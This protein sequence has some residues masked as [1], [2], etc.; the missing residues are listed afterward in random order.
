MHN[1]EPVKTTLYQSHVAAGA[2]IVDFHGFMMPLRYT[3]ETREHLNVRTNAGLFD[4]SHMGEIEVTGPEALNYLQ[5]ITPNNVGVLRPGQCQYSVL[6]REDGTAVDDI[7]ISC[8]GDNHYFICVNAAN[9]DKDF[10]HFCA[11]VPKG[12][13]VLDL[14]ADYDQL[15]IQGPKALTLLAALCKD[16]VAEMPPFTFI[17]TQI[18][19][20]K[21]IFAT[22]GYTGERGGEMY[23]SPKDSPRLWDLLLDKGREINLQP[24]GLA[25]R[26]T[27]RLEMGYMLFGND[28]NDDMS[29]IEAGLAWVVKFDKGS[30]FGRERLWNEAKE[31]KLRRRICGLIMEDAGIPRSNY[32]VCASGTEIGKV[33]SGGQSPTLKRG[34]AL[35]LLDFPRSPGEQLDVMIRDKANRAMQVKPPFIDK[36][37]S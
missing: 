4:V 14:T 26:D 36:R 2:K 10:A 19:G 11:C 18:E 30:F 33:T 7:I 1:A 5:M 28:L 29:P 23:V 20:M 35:A 34:I 22:T 31:G 24:T 12:A 32:I 13:K 9:K 27:L 21:V 6:L 8:F 25:A 37:R 16:P 3:S 17:R 15:A